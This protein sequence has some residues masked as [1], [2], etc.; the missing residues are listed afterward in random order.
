MRD[1]AFYLFIYLFIYLSIYLFIYLSLY[2][3]IYYWIFVIFIFNETS[4]LLVLHRHPT[5][6][7]YR[8]VLSVNKIKMTDMANLNV[9]LMFTFML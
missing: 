5:N 2:L 3:F 7:I 6:L 4:L 1:N 8:D 9:C